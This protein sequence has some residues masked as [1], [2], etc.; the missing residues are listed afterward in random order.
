[1][2]EI[3]QQGKEEKILK[4]QSSNTPSSRLQPIPSKDIKVIIDEKDFERNLK[5]HELKNQEK[6]ILDKK[7]KIDFEISQM[8]MWAYAKIGLG[9][10]II[11]YTFRNY[12]SPRTHLKSMGDD[13]YEM[14]NVKSTL[15]P[16]DIILIILIA[17]FVFVLTK[18]RKKK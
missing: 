18:G 7:E 11:F 10:F 5:I 13:N 3:G 8:K 9:I 6:E 1:M 15:A 16:R 12:L 14:V 4:E 17:I 2:L